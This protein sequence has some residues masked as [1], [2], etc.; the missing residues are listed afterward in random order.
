[1]QAA[2]GLKGYFAHPYAAGEPGTNENTNGL[3]REFFPK[4]SDFSTISHQAVGCAA[5][6][7]IAHANASSSVVRRKSWRRFPVL[8]F[9][10]EFTEARV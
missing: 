5:A 10:F 7:L 9:N 1:L 4:G 2:L 8:H 6:V 3:L